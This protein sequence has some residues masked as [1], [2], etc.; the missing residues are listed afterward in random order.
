MSLNHFDLWDNIPIE[1]FKS[2]GVKSVF[3]VLNRAGELVFTIGQ[4]PV[5]QNIQ[6]F[7]ISNAAGH[8]LMTFTTTG[9]LVHFVQV[10]PL[11]SSSSKPSF[12]FYYAIYGRTSFDI[13]IFPQSIWIFI[14]EQ[15]LRHWRSRFVELYTNTALP[16][17]LYFTRS[18][19]GIS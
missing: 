9:L 7:I 14:V 15:G 8:G 10:H 19:Q 17:W 18:T 5:H 16:R 6:S 12:H 4:C 2:N 1:P 3:H 13:I 11:I